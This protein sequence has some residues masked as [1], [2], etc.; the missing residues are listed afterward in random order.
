MRERREKERKEKKKE[1]AWNEQNGVH[2]R[3]NLFGA[4][5]VPFR[6]QSWLCAAGEGSAKNIITH[7][8]C[9]LLENNREKKKT[10]FIL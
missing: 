2:V 10:T 5:V 9:V 1:F 3:V 6:I 8:S 7:E 4:P